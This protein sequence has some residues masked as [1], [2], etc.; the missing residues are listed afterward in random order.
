LLDQ[1]DLQIAGI[2]ECDAHLDM[3]VFSA[4][5]EIVG[6]DPV[7]VVPGPDTHH[8]DPVIHGGADVADHIAV[9]GDRTE[10]ATHAGITS[11]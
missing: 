8:V 10:N 3:R 9:L 2:G 1:L 4:V 7:D 6:L 5:T 11:P